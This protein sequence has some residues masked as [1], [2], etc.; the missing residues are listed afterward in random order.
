MAA[1]AH[2]HHVL[3]TV[4]PFVP[5]NEYGIFQWQVL[6]Y[7]IQIL[8]KYIIMGMDYSFLQLGQ[9]I[10]V[11]RTLTNAPQRLPMLPLK[12]IPSPDMY[13]HGIRVGH[14][15]LHRTKALSVYP[16]NIENK[17]LAHLLFHTG[18]IFLRLI[19]AFKINPWPM[20]LPDV[21][22]KRTTLVPIWS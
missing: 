20:I 1:M 19:K 3:P 4:L 6:A 9:G 7:P 16:A 14:N 10:E 17:R 11:I 12:I 15:L 18:K 22:H 13:G 8:R 21:R 5:I 2:Q